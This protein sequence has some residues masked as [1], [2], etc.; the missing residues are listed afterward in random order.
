MI[1]KK[2]IW[3]GLIVIIVAAVAVRNISRKAAGPKKSALG[4]VGV[5]VAEVTEGEL[6]QQVTVAGTVKSDL[7]INLVPKASGRV[8][9][10][11]VDV[12]STVRAGQVLLRLDSSD[13]QAAVKQAQA[14]LAGAKARFAQ[15]QAGASS[16]DL[17]QAKA[18]V[19]QARASME[20]ARKAL[21]AAKSQYQDRTSTQAQIDAA[22]TQLAVRGS[23]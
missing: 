2:W 15:V 21:A 8:L 3:I 11:A 19:N 23:C 12:G 18:Q 20:G 7:E 14:G 6:S 16:Q 10:V 22:Q 13:Y 9:S 17:K 1:E 5:V 4:E